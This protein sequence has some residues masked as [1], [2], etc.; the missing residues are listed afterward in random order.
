M[1]EWGTISFYFYH[2][3]HGVCKVVAFFQQIRHYRVFDLFRL[4]KTVISIDE[5]YRVC[6]FFLYG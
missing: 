3:L 5:L 2:E 1:Y 4:H 6:G